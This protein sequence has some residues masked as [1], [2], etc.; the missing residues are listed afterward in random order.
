ME[1]QWRRGILYF[2]GSCGPEEDAFNIFYTFVWSKSNKSAS[3]AA[4]LHHQATQV[5]LS[6]HC[7]LIWFFCCKAAAPTCLHNSS[8]LCLSLFSSH[9]CF[10]STALLR[11]R[12]PP[13]QCWYRGVGVRI[14][15]RVS[16]LIRPRRS[17]HFG[18]NTVHYSWLDVNSHRAEE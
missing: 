2:R 11:P 4:G 17:H 7:F 8:V 6:M 5:A 10:A 12:V 18:T 1:R 13:P 14:C 3:T 9:C 15:G 16:A